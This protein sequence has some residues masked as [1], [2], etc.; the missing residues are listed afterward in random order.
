MPRSRHRP[1]GASVIDTIASNNLS[2]EQQRRLESLWLEITRTRNAATACALLART[3]SDVLHVGVAILRHGPDGWSGE[4]WSE[5]GTAL[6]NATDLP[7]MSEALADA[8]QSGTGSPVE[9]LGTQWTGVPLGEAN[10]AGMWLMI[11]PGAPQSWRAAS[12]FEP[13][14]RQVSMAL[15]ITASSDLI[16]ERERR[17]RR[18]H[19][20]TQRLARAN[21]DNL[22]QLI[23]D[24]VT[25]AVGARIGSLAVYSPDDDA[26]RITATHGYPAAMVQ[27]VRAAAGVGVLGKVFTSR[28]PLLVSD[29]SAGNGRARPRYQT[30][31]F[32]AIP[33]ISGD[34]GFGVVTVTDHAE[35]RPFD[36]QELAMARGL[37]GPAVLA[38][39][40]ERVSVRAGELARITSI[41]PL[42]GLTNRREFQIRLED[43]LERARRYSLNLALLMI[44]IDGFK[45]CNDSFGHVAGDMVLQAVAKVLQRSVRRFD[46]CARYG[47]DEFAIMTPGSDAVRAVQSAERIRRRIAMFQSEGDAPDAPPLTASIGVAVAVPGQ[48]SIQLITQADR[49]LYRAKASGRDC[50]QI[51]EGDPDAH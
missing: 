5:P 51:A 6:G 36:R 50:V 49:A 29:V 1:R 16:K 13:F 35:G 45:A 3:L 4:K 18:L 15:Q 46:V 22:H 44:D 41:D 33:L 9:T 37:A 14:V 31:S 47:G 43:E 2:G 7:Q 20:F 8:A 26:L 21:Q 10:A 42:T 48:S 39:A 24:T 40:R 34:K 19:V 27:H 25:T 23:V 30:R 17:L 12:W 38:L 28:K 32:M 11:L